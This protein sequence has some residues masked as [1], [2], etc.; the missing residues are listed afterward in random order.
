MSH[1]LPTDTILE[2]PIPRAAAR[3]N[4]APIMLPLWLISAS[5]PGSSGSAS[6]AAFSVSG[7]RLA[8][9][10]TPRQF[11]PSSRSPPARATAT[12][13]SCRSRPTASASAKPAEKMVAAV[14][15]LS[16]QPAMASGTSRAATMMKAWSTGPSTA[17]MLGKA[18]APMISARPGLIG[19]TR[20]AN[21]SR[22]SSRW[23]REL[24]FAGSAEAPISA[25]EAGLNRASNSVMRDRP[26][27]R[28]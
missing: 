5:L 10:T 25:I 18:G 22:A 20:P 27:W 23:A 11:G 8:T 7:T 13:A 26:C 21:P 2:N 1:S 19:M 14:T 12:I 15:P 24:S 28:Q 17:R 16:I 3:E 4:S 6:M 9:L